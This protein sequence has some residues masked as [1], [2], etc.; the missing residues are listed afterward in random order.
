[1]NGSAVYLCKYGEIVLKGANRASFEAMLVKELKFRLGHVGRFDVSRGQSIIYVKPSDPETDPD[2]LA[3][4][5]NVLFSTFGINAVCRAVRTD[6]ELESIRRTAVSG[7]SSELEK[8]KTFKVETKR[9]DKRFP[10]RSAEM[11][12]MLGGDILSAYPH[13]KVDVHNP[14]VTVKCDIRDEGAYLSAGQRRA[15]GGM[16]VASN[17]KALLLLSGGIDSPVAGWMAAKRGL[18]LEAVY[19][20]ASPYTSE[21]AK[22]KVRSLASVIAG[23]SGTISLHVVSLTEIEESI[24][25]ACREEYFTLI[26]R[27]F[28]MKIATKIATDA[29]CGGLVTGDSL[30]QVASQTLEALAVSDDAAGLPVIRPCIGLDKEEIISRARMIGSFDTSILPY[31]DCCTV[32]TPRHPKTRPQVQAVRDEESKLDIEKLI[33][34]ALATDTVEK[35]RYNVP[36]NAAKE[37]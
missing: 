18:K 22:D 27:R 30:G 20:E 37:Y 35:I 19:F 12:A 13:L 7:L 17:G 10:V 4:A 3:A 34:A 1:M 24:S 33:A 23:W 9:A 31:E 28:M 25:R 5:E 32:F 8:A 14:D 21:L 29:G 6:A 11:S 2:T 36:Q 16:P 15:A 26:L